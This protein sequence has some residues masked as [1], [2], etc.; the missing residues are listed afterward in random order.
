MESKFITDVMIKLYQEVPTE[1]L[2]KIQNV[3]YMVVDNYEI[4][5]KPTDIVPYEDVIPECY[6]AYFVSLKINGKS[7]GTIRLYNSVLKDFIY[8][9]KKS[10]DKITV[11]DVRVYL[12]NL[13]IRK[14]ISNRT[15]NARRLI[16]NGFFEWLVN[17]DYITKNPCRNIKTIKYAVKERKP[18]TGIQLEKVRD[19]CETLREKAMIEFLYS[20]GCRVSELSNCK[21]KDVDMD[22][23]EVILFG[24]GS[25]YRT[26]YLSSKSSL[27][28]KKYLA[29]RT[30]DSEYL[31]VTERKPYRQLKKGGIEAIVRQI[32]ERADIDINLHPH[33]LR[34][35]NATDSINR[36]MP[37]SD[38][39]KILGHSDINT[40]M[41]YAKVSGEH[42]HM[43]HRRCIV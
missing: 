41:I 7:D 22:N 28:L 25:K 39:Q 30:D 36:G 31:F 40:T 34:H 5:D 17:E 10:V 8:T 12:Y 19:A 27:F 14:G 33:L 16:L 37:V 6:K 26:S 11:N 13:Q 1:Y 20:T 23:G 38:V 9:V 2:P 29:S 15:L 4:Q 24:K 32:G 18:L 3:L 43:E 21:I 35:T 42:T